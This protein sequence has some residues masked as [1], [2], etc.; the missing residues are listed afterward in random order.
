MTNLLFVGIGGAIGAVLRFLAGIITVKWV[1]KSDVLT[2]TVMANLTGCFFAGAALGWAVE[3]PAVSPEAV[4]FI[5]T[6]I[7]GSLT[8]FSTFA[9][10][11]WQ[12]VK[13]DTITQLLFYL[14]LQ[15]VAAFLMTVAGYFT[16]QIISAP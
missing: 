6:G 7:L 5:S 11:S 1:G 3:N 8:T 4:L 2:G 10:E 12:L 13:K 9:L 15:V 14:C 16:I